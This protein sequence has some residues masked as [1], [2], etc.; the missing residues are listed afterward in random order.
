MKP[1]DRSRFHRPDRRSRAHPGY[2][3]FLVHRISGLL[4]ALFLPMHFWLL[5]RSLN[6]SAE[7]DAALHWVDRPLFKLAE[8]GLVVLL[9]AH[10]AG[11]MRVMMIELLP[12]RDW[13]KTLIAFAAAITLIIG[14]AMALNMV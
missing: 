5:S 2:V 6:G 1:A 13:Q 7:L 3:A 12:W 14:A 4:L 11:G 9:A 10:L 8:W